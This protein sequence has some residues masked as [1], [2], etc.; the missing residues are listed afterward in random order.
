MYPPIV[1]LRE[2]GFEGK[3]MVPSDMTSPE[4]FTTADQTELISTHY[5]SED[6]SIT[7]GVWECAPSV[8][9]IDAYPC[10]EMMTV[11]AGSVTIT[12]ENG[13]AQTFAKGDTFFIAKGAKCTWT[14]TETMKKFYMIAT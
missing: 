5:E 2:D 3:G 13:N 1:R 6:G 4:A 12:D 14:I 8:E 9:E 7:T 11:L 10:N